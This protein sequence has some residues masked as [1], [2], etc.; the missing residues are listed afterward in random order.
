VKDLDE[1]V[2]EARIVKQK[3]DEDNRKLNQIH[4][5]RTCKK[6]YLITNYNFSDNVEQMKTEIFEQ[7][8]KTN[9][10]VNSQVSDF[11]KKLDGVQRELKQIKAQ[12][13]F[14]Q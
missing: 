11:T 14:A 12:N 10:D 4:D 7:L 2:R 6:N 5:A 1:K 9:T 3:E 13:I 8:V